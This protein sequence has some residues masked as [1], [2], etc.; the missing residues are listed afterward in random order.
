MRP[1]APA[2]ARI[3]FSATQPPP[4]ETRRR[5]QS[6]H[7]LRIRHAIELLLRI[8]AALTRD[9][10]DQINR[11]SQ[12]ARPERGRRDRPANASAA[13]VLSGTTF[14]HRP[15]QDNSARHEL[16]ASVGMR[17][18]AGRR[19]RFFLAAALLAAVPA[20]TL[21]QDAAAATETP[22][23][24]SRETPAPPPLLRRSAA[25]LADEVYTPTP[26]L[27]FGL[28]LLRLPS[29]SYMRKLWRQRPE[30][31]VIE[32]FTE[33]EKVSGDEIVID[34]APV[35]VVTIQPQDQKTLPLELEEARR[36]ALQHQ[37]EIQ[38]ELIN[39]AIARAQ[40]AEAW[41][42]FDWILSGE[43]SRN[44]SKPLAPDPKQTDETGALAL[45]VPLPTGAV[46]QVTVPLTKTRYN[47]VPAGAPASFYTTSPVVSVTQPVLRGAGLRINLAPINRA[48]LSGQQTEA[49]T[50]LL[51]NN[52]LANVDR[53]Y[54]RLWAAQRELDVRYEQFE[55]AQRQLAHADRLAG[56]GLVPKMEILRSRVGIAQ[57]VNNIIVST[58]NRR[59]LE[60][61]FK[62]VLNMPGIG[63]DSPEVI[64]PNTPPE[65]EP[66]SLDTEKLVKLALDARMDLMIAQLQ[67]AVALIDKDVA[68]NQ[69]LPD[70]S[71][72]FEGS[73]TAF[74][75]KSRDTLDQADD[76]E[77]ENWAG[78]VRVSIPIGGIGSRARM[79]QAS[80][81]HVASLNTLEQRKRIIIQD[82]YDAVDR[83]TQS[84]Q[85][86]QAAE[87]EIA[88]TQRIYEAE[89]QLFERSI[90]TSTEVLDAAQ[91]VANAQVRH[92]SAVAEFQIA[93]VELA[94]A[95][96]AHLGYARVELVP[97]GGKPRLKPSP[98]AAP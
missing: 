22:S 13:S 56:A 97:H 7:Q 45:T 41:S 2:V 28:D 47:P 70:V 85:Q 79:R 90:R 14:I 69:L 57:R 35:P 32:P 46:A 48:R 55:L 84:W 71:L 12:H 26:G 77:I 11:S 75:L 72:F 92:L 61:D 68:R 29:G 73:R 17:A 74:G 37:L 40:V 42:R 82:V 62:R 98:D 80:L 76:G 43:A 31:R 51:I 6:Q 24:P 15:R 83:V 67:V 34:G 27:W 50:K 53:A 5:G 65:L 10:V 39:P 52:L 44:V 58:N 1:P 21:A 60:R 89:L 8:R 93:K 95:T 23:A 87:E 3:E 88:M 36:A 19:L 63:I 20:T 9:A 81:R 64:L 18:N 94:Y 86:I 30:T 25:D 49:Q 91:F 78:G 33:Y 16:H 96:G 4:G 59:F 54:W 38:A 66:L